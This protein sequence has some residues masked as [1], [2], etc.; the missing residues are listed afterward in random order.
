MRGN[1]VELDHEADSRPHEVDLVALDPDTGLGLLDAPALEERQKA[2]LQRRSGS[3]PRCLDRSHQRCAAAA[4]IVLDYG[5]E[6]GQVEA[7]SVLRLSYNSSQRLWIEQVG[8]V[9][10]RARHGGH[11][12]AVTLG[13]L[14]RRESTAAMNAYAGPP[15]APALRRNRHVDEC[16]TAL[17]KLP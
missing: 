16:G 14:L 2:V 11:G 9:Q 13:D 3:V 4:W 1:P 10:E 17:T 15:D 8:E 6:G 7:V 12:D 5:N